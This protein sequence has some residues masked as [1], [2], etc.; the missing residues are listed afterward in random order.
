[1]ASSSNLFQAKGTSLILENA[2][3]GLRNILDI[4]IILCIDYNIL[5][6]ELYDINGV[7]Y[8]VILAQV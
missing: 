5:M 1:M 3:A 2:I 7:A 6:N 8:V 4:K